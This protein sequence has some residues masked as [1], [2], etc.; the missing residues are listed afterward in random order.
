MVLIR[1]LRAKVGLGE[2]RV[3]RGRWFK[4]GGFSVWKCEFKFEM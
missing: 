3:G 1:N 2:V 4:I